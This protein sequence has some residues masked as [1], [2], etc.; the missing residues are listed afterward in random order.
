[1]LHLE[2]GFLSSTHENFIISKPVWYDI[3]ALS[4]EMST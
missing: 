2:Y 1:M 3:V 4:L